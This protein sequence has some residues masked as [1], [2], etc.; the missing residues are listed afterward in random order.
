[1]AKDNHEIHL[2]THQIGYSQAVASG[3]PKAI[4]ALKDH[5]AMHQQYVNMQMQ[6]APPQEQPGVKGMEGAVPNLQNA[7]PS[8]ASL[9]AGVAGA[10]AQV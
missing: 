3:N 9:D 1:M 2:Q 10:G 6:Q 5:I 8:Q 7:V 4:R